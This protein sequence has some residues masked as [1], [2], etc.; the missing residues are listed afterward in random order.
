MTGNS[1]PYMTERE[2]LIFG[3]LRKSKNFCA[4]VQDLVDEPTL[5]IS[6]STLYRDLDRLVRIGVV[7]S[8]T[9]RMVLNSEGRQTQMREYTIAPRYQLQTQ[10]N[11][12]PVYFNFVSNSPS[13]LL[14]T[15]LN[16][17]PASEG[18]NQTDRA[19]R[20]LGKLLVELMAL[21][22]SPK[23][24]GEELNFL[25]LRRWQIQAEMKGLIRLFQNYAAWCD[26]LLENPTLWDDT[27]FTYSLTQAVQ[28]AAPALKSKLQ[29]LNVEQ[30]DNDSIVF[31]EG[32]RTLGESS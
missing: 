3:V 6:R 7:T 9:L 30:S 17:K 28:D 12:V 20:L 5:D 8:N 4:T 10:I 18:L 19:V 32:V 22:S 11:G 26:Q 21:A 29:V 27:F 2:H 1:L 25:Q 13:S 15:A 14:D 31:T 23:P 16:I 24:T